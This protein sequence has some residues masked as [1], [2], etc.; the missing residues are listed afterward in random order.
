MD[1]VASMLIEHLDTADTVVSPL[2]I[3]PPMPRRA[4]RIPGLRSVRLSHNLDRLAGRFWHYPRS[5]RGIIRYCDVFHIVDHSYSH[6]LHDL[7]AA[8]TVVTLHDLDTFRCLL[9][10]DS[11]PR[12]Y[13]FRKMTG[14]ILSGFLKAARIVCVSGTTRRELTRYGIVE[15][16]K[17][18]VIPNGVDPRCTAEP[19]PEADAELDRLV[20]AI[21]SASQ[22]FLHVGSTIPRK[23]IDGLL[24]IFAALRSHWPHAILVR[25]GG[26]F[27]AC[28]QAL[29]VELGLSSSIHSLPFIRRAVLNAAYQRASL[30]LLP[31]L[32]EGFG[33]PLI[34]AM[35]CGCPVLA[36]GLEVFREV[37]GPNAFYC[38]A[39]EPGD[40][41]EAAAAVLGMDRLAFSR[42]LTGYAARFS[43]EAAAAQTAQLY[44]TL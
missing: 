19:D 31:S 44:R 15:E 30:L 10:P 34:E 36:S 20:P 43:W 2:R 12:P 17:T 32:A 21:A 42:Q 11:D 22:V 3:Q 29:A 4:G 35:A 16:S 38:H 28:Q 39:A 6:L 13:W 23:N 18:V 37:G 8:R 41:L 27:T 7:P 9:D 25:A 24:R 5:L 1:L 40:W 26:P 33:L 14:H